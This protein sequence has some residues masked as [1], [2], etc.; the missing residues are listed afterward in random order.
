MF[1][2]ARACRSAIMKKK[3][4]TGSTRSGGGGASMA[5]IN[6]YNQANNGEDTD[7]GDGDNDDDDDDDVEEGQYENTNFITSNSPT[8]NHVERSL[9]KSENGSTANKKH[10]VIFKQAGGVSNN[11]KIENNKNHKKHEK[12]KVK[13]TNKEANNPKKGSNVI[14]F[15]KEVTAE[16]GELNS[17]V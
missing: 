14:A 13:T 9:E 5:N 15:E 12:S 4:T 16:N 6:N 7:K 3:S 10:T 11:N 8:T 1:T 17:N 2:L